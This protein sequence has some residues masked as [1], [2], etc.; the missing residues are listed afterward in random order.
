LYTARGRTRK[1][2]IRN[3]AYSYHDR[4]GRSRGQWL[5]VWRVEIRG[6][7][8]WSWHEGGRPQERGMA[9]H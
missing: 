2:R 7:A 1:D 3:T 5:R 4:Q 9:A 6:C 8:K